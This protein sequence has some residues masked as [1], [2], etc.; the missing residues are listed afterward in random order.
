MQGDGPSKPVQTVSVV[1]LGK[2]GAPIAACFAHKGYQVIGVDL[3]AQTVRLINEGR[4]PVYEPELVE[5]ISANRA[6]LHATDDVEQAILE[7]EITFIVVPTPS[8]ADGGF[9]LRYVLAA[10]ERIGNALREKAYHLIVLTS[11]V[12]PGATDNDVRSA[13]ET[14]SGKRCGRDF[15]LC[16][17]PEFIALGSVINDLLNPDFIL[18]GESDSHAGELLASFY[19][20]IHDSAPPIARMSVINAEITKLSVNT[21]VT[22]KITFANMLARICERLPG[23]NVDVVTSALGLDSRIGR[24]YLKGAIGYGGPCFP[25]DNMALSFLAQRLGAPATLA[26]ATDSANRLQVSYLAGLVKSKLPPGG[27]VGILGLAYKQNTEVV[28]EAQGLLLAQSLLL[29]D[30]PVIVYDPAA[31]E[32]ARMVLNGSVKFAASV[33]ECIRQSDVVVIATPWEEFRS[34]TPQ[35]LE[36]QSRHPV[37]VDCWRLLK[38]EHYAH[39]ADYVA[40]GVGTEALPFPTLETCLN[41]AGGKEG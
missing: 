34:I 16:Y 36:R 31:M 41:K 28:E 13:L 6:R 4:A 25:R 19:R 20:S 27:A 24:K 12:L 7:S 35:M 21:F 30:V 8:K 37:L 39:L 23:A 9:S 40:L 38:A 18:I 17:N 11:T 15:G 29:S 10:C 5:M 33:E 3:N 32:N 22:T 26:E 2:L 1:G 14:H